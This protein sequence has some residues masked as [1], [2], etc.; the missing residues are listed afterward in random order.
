M[1]QIP[2]GESTLYLTQLNWS[3]LGTNNELFTFL[4]MIDDLLMS[5]RHI[6]L[7]THK[8]HPAIVFK[9]EVRKL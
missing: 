7:G 1:V 3:R 4:Y 8:N 5:S 6:K 9:D 2:Q